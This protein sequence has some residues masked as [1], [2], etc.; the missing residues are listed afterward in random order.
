MTK[1]VQL[2]K[3]DVSRLVGKVLGKSV[4]PEKTPIKESAKTKKSRRVIR[5]N[6]EEMIDFLDKMA[7]KLELSKRRRAK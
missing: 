1:I 4:K 5:L 7:N 3:E 2:T 6:E